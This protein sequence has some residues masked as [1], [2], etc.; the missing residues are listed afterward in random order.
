MG[1]LIS[2]Q[3]K[4][5]PTLCFYKFPHTFHNTKGIRSHVQTS[6]ANPRTLEK[7]ICFIIVKC[8][9]WW[10]QKRRQ[11]CRYIT[12]TDRLMKYKQSIYIDGM[13]RVRLQH[14]EWVK[15]NMKWNKHNDDDKNTYFEGSGEGLWCK[16]SSP[17]LLCGG[18]EAFGSDANNH[19]HRTTAFLL[20]CR[21]NYRQVLCYLWVEKFL[22]MATSSTCLSVCLSHHLPLCLSIY[23]SLS[24]SVSCQIETLT[25]KCVM[26]IGALDTSTR[27][28]SWGLSDTMNSNSP[29]SSP[30]MYILGILVAHKAAFTP[31]L[32]VSN[33]LPPHSRIWKQIL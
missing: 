16:G 32:T 19:L 23:F 15:N 6:R 18:D 3:G 31:R 8:M 27:S 24:L 5:D 21:V 17:E 10:S 4:I 25:L 29:P 9:W 12:K 33:K 11:T 20:W 7:L 1:I 14:P 28:T 13:E 2:F 26:R 30:V 22:V